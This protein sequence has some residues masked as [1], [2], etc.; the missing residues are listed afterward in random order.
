MK[1]IQLV[2]NSKLIDLPNQW[3]G[4]TPEQYQRLVGNL[5]RMAAGEISPGEVRIRLLC[6]LMGW[7]VSKIKD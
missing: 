6:D 2:Y 5:L 1:N 7:R 3:E 4:L